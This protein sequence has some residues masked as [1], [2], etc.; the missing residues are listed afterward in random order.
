MT[1]DDLTNFNAIYADIDFEKTLPQEEI[2]ALIQE[3]RALVHEAA[4]PNP[5]SITRTKNGAHF[6]WIFP[7]PLEV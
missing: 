6:L 4:L 2:T 7:A 5:T 3:K 1:E